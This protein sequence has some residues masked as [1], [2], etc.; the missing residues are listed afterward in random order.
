MMGRSL[1]VK[2]VENYGTCS[3]IIVFIS[4]NRSS[5]IAGEVD[6]VSPACPNIELTILKFWL[7]C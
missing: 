2:Y 1:F 6:D 7:C 4:I 3:V 5:K